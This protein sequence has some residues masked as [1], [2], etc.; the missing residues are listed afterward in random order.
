[1]LEVKSSVL[2][3]RQ[4]GT[5]QDSNELAD[6]LKDNDLFFKIGKPNASMSDKLQ[7]LILKLLIILWEQ[8]DEDDIDAMEEK[9]QIIDDVRHELSFLRARYYKEIMSKKTALFF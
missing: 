2:K 3:L 6:F 8:D 7:L 1:M 9:I 5:D 4:S